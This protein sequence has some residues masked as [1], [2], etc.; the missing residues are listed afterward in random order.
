MGFANKGV[1]YLVERLKKR[2]VPGIVGVNICKNKETPLHKS[3]GDYS[4]CITK[5][6]PYVD[7]ITINISSPNTP[8]LR[9]LQ[10]EEYLNDLLS[11][12]NKTKQEL[13]KEHNRE[14]PLLVKTVID[15]SD[16]DLK[17]L[18]D[19]LMKHDIAGVIV[20]NTS[21]DHSSVANL[22]HGDEKGGL[23]GKPLFAK[24]TEII[25]TIRE[26]TDGKL[27][28]IAVGGVMSVED[29]KAK[30]EL[31]ASLVQVYTGLVYKGPNLVR[32]IIKEL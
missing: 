16:E 14:V 13:I 28:V 32:E 19:M 4:Y 15:L 21:V 25:K 12:I 18:L 31:G 23:S 6:Y 9:D 24:S 29:A 1:N 17:K 2:K 30:F 26:M 11:E 8:G 3:A 20:S 10:S 27:P 22:V 7:F 5:L